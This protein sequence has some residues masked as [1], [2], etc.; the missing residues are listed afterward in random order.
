MKC[1]VHGVEGCEA[2]CC[3]VWQDKKQNSEPVKPKNKKHERI[4]LLII[5]GAVLIWGLIDIVLHGLTE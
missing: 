2:L 3:R 4:I 1:D 5:L